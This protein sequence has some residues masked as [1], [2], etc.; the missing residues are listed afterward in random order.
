MTF[1]PTTFRPDS[2]EELVEGAGAAVADAAANW[3]NENSARLK[4]YLAAI[5]EAVFQTKLDFANGVIGREQAQVQMNIHRTTL[6]VYLAGL[7]YETFELKQTV[8]DA[9][10]GAVG[11]A[12]Y[13][14][15]GINF[16]P[17]LVQA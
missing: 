10:I 17:S 4:G 2:V 1:D 13:N 5:G 12:V 15:T 6:R 16:A 7:A 3:F 9:A 14:L 11:Y 8:L